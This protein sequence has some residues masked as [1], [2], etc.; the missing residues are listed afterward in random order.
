MMEGK[1]MGGGKPLCQI[2]VPFLGVSY[3]VNP[4]DLPWDMINN[5][6]GQ[7]E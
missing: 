7:Q 5:N 3:K 2:F 6:A 4:L 1:R